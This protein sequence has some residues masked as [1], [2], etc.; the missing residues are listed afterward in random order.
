MHL[1]AVELEV[2]L[3]RGQIQAVHLRPLVAD[4][5][6]GVGPVGLEIGVPM[7]QRQRVMLPQVLLVDD[8]EAGVVQRRLDEPG[9]GEVAVGEDVSVEELGG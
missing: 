9:R 6:D 7:M 1:D 8:L 3:A 5:I 4:L 2:Q